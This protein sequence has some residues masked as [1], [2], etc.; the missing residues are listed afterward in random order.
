MVTIDEFSRLASAVHAS[1]IS[2][3]NWTVALDETSRLLG[4]TACGLVAGTGST[5]SVLAATIPREAVESY[6]AYYRRIDFVLDACEHGPAG[7][8]RGGHELVAHK[9]QSEFYHDWQRPFDLTDGLFVRLAG[10]PDASF[11]V[12]APTKDEPFETAERVKLVQALIPHVQQALRTRDHLS[13][14]ETSSGD[15]T[16][17]IDAMR[18]GIVIVDG[19]CNV[20]HLNAAAQSILT[21]EDGMKLRARRIES[22]R[23]LCNDKLQAGVAAAC[24]TQQTTVRRGD[25]LAI[26]R[27]SGKRPYILHIVPLGEVEDPCGAKALV[28]IIDP[29]GG[30]EPPKVLLRQLFDLTNAE[31]DVALRMLRGDGVNPVADDLELS[32]ATVKT[33]LQHIFEKT[34]THRQAELTRVLLGVVR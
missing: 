33:H 19:G 31:A 5:R 2:P 20:V 8:V 6:D 12:T 28:M 30:L 21:A 32:A 23:M 24:G 14:L 4:A 18:H 13:E 11:V 17:V 27:P 7:L 15:I 16:A 34:G 3:E 1:A 26:G 10:E 22:T 9:S 25:S 29:E